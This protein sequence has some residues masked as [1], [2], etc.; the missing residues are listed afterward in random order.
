MNN[1]NLPPLPPTH[2]INSDT[3]ALVQLYLGIAA[4]LSDD[5]RWLLS[6]HLQDCPDCSQEWEMLGRVNRSVASLKSSQPSAR[7]DQAVRAAI[8]AKTQQR[9]V[10][11]ALFSPGKLVATGVSSFGIIVIVALFIIMNL[12]TRFQLPEQLSWN[13]Y[14]LYY[15]QTMTDNTGKQYHIQTYHNLETNQMNV[16]T[17]MGDEIHVETVS[18]THETLGKD[19]MHHIAQWDISDWSSDDSLFNLKELRSDLH[20]GKAQYLGQ[21]SFQG[22]EVYRIRTARGVTLLLNMQYL[23]V[24]VLQTDGKQGS[25]PMYERISWLQPG[26]IPGSMWQME[27]PPDYKMGRLPPQPKLE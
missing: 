11:Q 10:R 19:I 15:S 7:V 23:P 12:P 3:C 6:R 8:I 26:Q 13:H 18:D 25:A 17:V 14:I 24:N 16:E 27:V 1:T 4:D 2:T 20:T 9:R 21:D 5:Q 22:Q